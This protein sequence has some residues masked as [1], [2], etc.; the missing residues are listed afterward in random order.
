MTKTQA[1]SVPRLAIMA[2]FAAFGVGVGALSGSMA[3]VTRTAGIDSY[4]LGLALMFNTVISVVIMS[5]GGVIARHLPTR[6]ALLVSLPFFAIVLALVLVSRSPSH[7]Y[8]GLAG[9]GLAMGWTD[10]TMNAEGSAIENDLRQPIFTQFHGAASA[11]MAATAIVASFLSE[12]FGTWA[13]GLASLA[14]FAGAWTMVRRHVPARPLAQR[15]TARLAGLPSR[16]PLLLLGLIAGLSITAEVTSIMW[17][18][19]LLDELAPALAAVAGLGVAFFGV[20]TALVRFP[21]DGLRARLGDLPLMTGSI[22]VAIAGFAIL[23][24]S[25]SFAVSVAGF[26]AVG[27]GTAA[28]VP[29]AFSLAASLVSANRAAGIGFVSLVAGLPRILGPWIF[30]MVSSA[31][32]IGQAFGLFTVALGSALVLVMTLKRVG[33]NSR[34]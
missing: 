14:A 2:V 8:L 10:V 7:F 11:A 1:Y 34:V 18:A 21:A 31:V 9:L 24:L 28:L 4:D 16:L 27:F 29:C 23:G 17:S 32:G 6:N 13:A 20:C 12:Y 15:H 5:S 22:A 30:G 33:L 25:N 26:A 19:R 3:A